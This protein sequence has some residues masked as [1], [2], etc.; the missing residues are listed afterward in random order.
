MDFLGAAGAVPA[1]KQGKGK[2]AMTIKFVTA[3][4]TGI[5]PVRNKEGQI[6]FLDSILF[7]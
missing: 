1:G 3:C 7:L 2:S 6:P 5:L 4:G